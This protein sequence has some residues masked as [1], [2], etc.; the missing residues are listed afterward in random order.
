[1]YRRYV[2]KKDDWLIYIQ[3]PLN[4]KKKLKISVEE[5]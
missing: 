1:M 4:E 2:A 3:L 5:E